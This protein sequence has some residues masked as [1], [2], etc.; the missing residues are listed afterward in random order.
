VTALRPPTQDEIAAARRVLERE[1]RWKAAMA[2][3]RRE[4][5]EPSGPLV[6]VVPGQPD[7]VVHAE[8]MGPPVYTF[9][10]PGH[11]I[12][13]TERSAMTTAEHR[14]SARRAVAPLSKTPRPAL[15]GPRQPEQAATRANAGRHG[16]V[17]ALGRAAV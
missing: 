10:L 12:E 1:E 7:R 9:V 11:L 15:N 16:Q 5:S 17:C 3:A 8:R 14:P 4:V 2:A 6:F 13:A